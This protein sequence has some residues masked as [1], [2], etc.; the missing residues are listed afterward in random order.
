VSSLVILVHGPTALESAYENSDLRK[1]QWPSWKSLDKWFLSSD[2][3]S[4]QRPSS[5]ASINAMV[6]DAMALGLSADADTLWQPEH[7]WK[8]LI[9]AQLIRDQRT[10]TYWKTW[11]ELDKELGCELLPA[12]VTTGEKIRTLAFSTLT[13]ELGCSGSV[14]RM[15]TYDR[16]NNEPSQLDSTLFVHNRIADTLAVIFRFCAW[17]VAETSVLD[18]EA[19]VGAGLENEILLKNLVPQFDEQ[20]SQWSRPIAEQLHG[21][22]KDCGFHG[23]GRAS[24][25]LGEILAGD[26]SDISDKQRT[27]RRWEEPYPGKPRD[28]AIADALHPLLSTHRGLWSSTSAQMRKFKFAWLNAVLLREML[29]KDLPWWHIQEVFDAFEDEFRKAR[30]LLGRPLS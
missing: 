3:Q 10:I 23:D 7:E 15:A 12:C 18:W 27:L 5:I 4:P 11:L 26:Y 20:S 29:Q 14:S 1:T 17:V 30:A 19:V 13:R 22:A 6:E 21:L 16:S 8:G 28:S 9:H 25:F 24:A 2:A